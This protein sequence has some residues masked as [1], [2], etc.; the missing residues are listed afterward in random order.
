MPNMPNN[1][2]N[3]LPVNKP[4]GRRNVSEADLNCQSVH[5]VSGELIVISRLK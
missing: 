3:Y 2:N 1:D 5:S 4:S